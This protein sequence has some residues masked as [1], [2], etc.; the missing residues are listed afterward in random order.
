MGHTG[1][2]MTVA[3]E[4]QSAHALSVFEHYQA[5][6]YF[7]S[8]PINETG[9]G[10]IITAAAT[11]PVRPNCLLILTTNGGTMNAAFHIARFLQRSYS[12]F[13]L[14]VPSHCKSA[15][16]LIAL[17]AHQLILDEYSELGPL[18][19]LLSLPDDIIDWSAAHQSR[20]A[21]DSLTESALDMFQKALGT[22]RPRAG[23]PVDYELAAEIAASMTTKL[24]EPLFSKVNPVLLAN[25]FRYN[26]TV[27][28]YGKRLISRSHNAR[29]ESVLRLIKSYPTHDFIVDQDDA[30][31]LFINVSTPVDQLY[32]LVDD[33][34][35]AAYF[36]EDTAL[37]QRLTEPPSAGGQAHISMPGPADTPAEAAQ[38][39]TTPPPGRPVP[40]PEPAQPP[41]SP[42]K[43]K[44]RSKS[45][46]KT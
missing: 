17:G 15:G 7:Y 41:D 18:D 25:D 39:D 43:V 40:Q 2:G 27:A 9:Y 20:F 24:Y 44:R 21:L 12:R 13:Q 16:T 45:G 46:R 32:A 26:A 14:Y 4:S 3:P 6:I 8:G 34:G 31:E 11:A 23:S 30:R 42:V 28:E 37:V 35:E 5:D 19:G 10:Q 1:N 22:M 33:L 38:P 29:L 36:Q